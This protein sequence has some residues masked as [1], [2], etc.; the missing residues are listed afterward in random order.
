MAKYALSNGYIMAKYILLR[1]IYLGSNLGP[2]S[3]Q[4]VVIWIPTYLDFWMP[5]VGVPKQKLETFELQ[6]N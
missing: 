6:N 2:K 4:N 3:L 5:D 1:R